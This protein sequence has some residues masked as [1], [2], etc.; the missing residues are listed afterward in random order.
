MALISK[1]SLLSFD[2]DRIKNYVFATQDLASIRGAS[3]ILHK[4]N[5]EMSK[6][7]SLVAPEVEQVYADGGSGLFLLDTKN[8]EAAKAA[9]SCHYRSKT[10]TASITGASVEITDEKQII[11]QLELLPYRLR[12]AKERVSPSKDMVSSSLMKTCESCGS[13]Y[14]SKS[15]LGPEGME[16]VCLSCYLKKRKDRSLKEQIPNYFSSNFRPEADGAPSL[17]QDL[18]NILKEREYG[19]YPDRQKFDRPNDF[20]ELGELSTPSGYIGLIVADGDNM[21]Q[22]FDQFGSLG[23]YKDFARILDQSLYDALANSIIKHLQPSMGSN[24]LPFDVLLL[25][26]DDLIMVTRAE[27][28]LPVALRLVEEFSSL[29]RG[30]GHELRLSASVVIA[31]AKYPFQAAHRIAESGL[32]FAKQKAHELKMQG[33]PCNTGLINFLVLNN[34]SFLDFYG[35]YNSEFKAMANDGLTSNIRTLRPYSTQMLLNLIRAA[36]DLKGAPS[37]RL[38]QLAE[39]CYQ[40]RNNSKLNGFAVVHRWKEN[41]IKEVQVIENLFDQIRQEQ[42]FTGRNAFPW[43]VDEKDNH[44]TPLVDL[45]ELFDFVK[46]GAL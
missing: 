11:D 1:K 28:V 35:I 44:Y 4:L 12:A 10:V 25:A 18:S 26:G 41:S 24:V 6:I 43:L 30:H 45:L 21:G 20:N 9:V 33:Q 38:Y 40:D 34:P 17:W 15:N 16:F 23:E 29:S 37:T 14:V 7:I 3:A 46:G 39:A 5:G 2:V 42:G 36:Q 8:V 22:V 31:H 27:S 19:G 13:G 32:R